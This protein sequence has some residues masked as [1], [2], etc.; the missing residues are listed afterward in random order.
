[1]VKRLVRLAQSLFLFVLA[2]TVLVGCGAI[3]SPGPYETAP[4]VDATGDD[5]NTNARLSAFSNSSSVN[6]LNGFD[7]EAQRLASLKQHPAVKSLA[8]MAVTELSKDNAAMAASYLE[9][10]QRIAPRDPMIYLNLAQVRL[11][12]FQYQQAEQLARKGIA[13]CRTGCSLTSSL[14]EL[15]ALSRAARNDEQGTEA[16]KKQASAAR[17]N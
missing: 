16:A 13:Y 9:R 15:I 1:M 17:L 2:S 10:A 8:Q 7:R 11:K 12:Q 6:D 14:W 3:L 5:A 4:V